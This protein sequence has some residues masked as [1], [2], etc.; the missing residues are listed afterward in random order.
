VRDLPALSDAI[1]AA[2]FRHE[3]QVHQLV[4]TRPGE[5]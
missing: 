3:D 5:D 2:Y 4:R 1:T